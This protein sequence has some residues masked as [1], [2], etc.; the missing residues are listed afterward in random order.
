MK[1]CPHCNAINEENKAIKCSVCGQ[2][3]ANEIEYSSEDLMDESIKQYITLNQSKLKTKRILKIVIPIVLIIIGIVA[4]ILIYNATR[5]KGHIIIRKSLYIM[6]VGE[7]I[8]IAPEY[9]G[10]INA[11]DLKLDI[12][13][14][15]TGDSVPFRYE[16]IDNK[17]Y[18]DAYMPDEITIVFSPNDDGMQKYFNNIVKIVIMTTE[19]GEL[20]E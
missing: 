3:I 16:I 12:E 7:R 5:P 15:S 6:Q 11:E 10:E 4:A 13:I 18:I 14:K 2:S 17:F 9:Y 1:V 19:H 20:N 8:E